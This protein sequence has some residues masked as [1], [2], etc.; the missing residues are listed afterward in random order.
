[1]GADGMIELEESDEE[2]EFDEADFKRFQEQ[3]LEE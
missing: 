1:M 3:M 2:N